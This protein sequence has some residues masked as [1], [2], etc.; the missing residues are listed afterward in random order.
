MTR[1]L[2]NPRVLFQL[3]RGLLFQY[4][5][6]R[7]W[8][9]GRPV[10]AAGEP[11][12]WITYPAIDFLAQFD[13]RD[14]AI[15]EWGSGFSTLWWARRC[16]QITTVESNEPWIPYITGLLPPSVEFIQ[17]ARDVDAEV[18]ALLDH[19]PIEHDVFIIDNYGSFRWRCAEV[20]AVN[21]A[22]G[23]LIILDN[24]DQCP[25]ACRV[26]RQAGFTQVDFTG[27]VPGNGYAHTTSIFW[28][29][30]IGFRTLEPDQ[31]QLS[32]AQPNPRW[33]DS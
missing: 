4:G 6:L 18:R 23:G 31:P 27:F 26:L 8:W 9:R 16:K 24:S 7:A 10:D 3:L 12:P 33:K 21:L 11:L 14:A 15:F 5:W 13:F 1:A 17:T 30:F 28:R 32:P 20:A 19:R 2:P 22:S 25:K 29:H